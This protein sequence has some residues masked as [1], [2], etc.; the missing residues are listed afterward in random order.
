VLLFFAFASEKMQFFRT[1]KAACGRSRFAVAANG[2]GALLARTRP[3]GAL[4]RPPCE[5]AATLSRLDVPLRRLPDQLFISIDFTGFFEP[6]AERAGGRTNLSA[7]D[8]TARS[9]RMAS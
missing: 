1:A 2:V 7:H 6:E 3:S 8:A 4:E 9:A 5:R